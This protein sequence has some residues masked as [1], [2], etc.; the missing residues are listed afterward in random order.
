MDMWLL[1][2]NN[3]ADAL[4][5]FFDLIAGRHLTSD[6]ARRLP[7]RTA[8]VESDAPFSIQVDGDPA[9]GGHHADI[10]IK[11]RAL[12]ILMPTDASYLLKN[13]K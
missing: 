3:V 11:H 13:K 9:L 5:H 12:K 1:S 7:F 2:G 8:R 10:T 6:Q 4:R